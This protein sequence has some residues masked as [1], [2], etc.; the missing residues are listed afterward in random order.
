MP[1][2]KIDPVAAERARVRLRKQKDKRD[3]ARTKYETE[4][5]KL[6]TE[7]FKAS[8]ATA[9]YEQIADDLGVSKVRVHAILSEQRELRSA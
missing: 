2:R 9:T 7:V 6:Y 4:Q 5:D 1:G 8:E 3:A